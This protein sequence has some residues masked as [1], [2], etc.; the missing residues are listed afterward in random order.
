[1]LLS[2]EGL[3]G[4]VAL[5]GCDELAEC[6]ASVLRGWQMREVAPDQAGEPVITIRKT[7]G[8]YS[9]TSRWLSEPASFSHPV[10]AT[11][12][13]LVDL[14]R[15]YVADN[16]HLLCLHCAAARF[17]DGLVI[18]PSTYRAGKST[19]SAHLAATGT[20][21]FTDDVLPIV[22]S[23]G[24]G[25]APGFLPRLRLPLPDDSGR[26]FVDF[27]EQMAGPRSDRYIY[28]DPGEDVLAPMGETAPIRGAVLLD[29]TDDGPAELSPAGADEI[30]QNAIQ[31]N[32]A[33]NLSGLETLDRLHAIVDGRECYTLRYRN[34]EDAVAALEGAFGSPGNSRNSRNSRKAG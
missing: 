1:M 11:C 25:M 7:D 33:H 14:M 2:F 29:R 23:T 32:F 31:R 4:P 18:F 30:L 28:F 12:D 15:A 13:F 27:I 5:T 34:A 17:G 10:N 22:A 3:T 20:R 8:R 16:A 21:L 9:R 24:H 19:L 26:G 6:I